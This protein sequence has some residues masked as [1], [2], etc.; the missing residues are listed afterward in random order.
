MILILA[1]RRDD[2]VMVRME[3]FTRLIKW[4]GRAVPGDQ[5]FIKK[6]EELVNV[7]RVQKKKGWFAGHMDQSEAHT[8]LTSQPEGTFLV[9]FSETLA[10]EGGFALDVAV[11]D[12]NDPLSFHIE[13]NDLPC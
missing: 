11:G 12:N 3:A 10:D 7:S 9:R 8:A 5:G 6:V 13:V 2:G 1:K 4:F